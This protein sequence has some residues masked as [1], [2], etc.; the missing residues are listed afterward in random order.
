L[1]IVIFRKQ[2]NQVLKHPAFDKSK[3]HILLEKVG[4][5]MELLDRLCDLPSRIDGVATKLGEVKKNYLPLKCMLC[6]FPSE[7][8]S[9]NN[10]LLSCILVI[11]EII[12][13]FDGYRKIM[14]PGDRDQVDVDVISKLL[15]MVM[16]VR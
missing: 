6:G 12:H 15:S 2:V 3:N 4:P 11:H 14:Q 10:T 16:A 9:S 13:T 7:Y 1:K 5:N 8:T